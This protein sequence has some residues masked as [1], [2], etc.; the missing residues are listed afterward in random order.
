MKKLF[1]LFLSSFL[2][3]LSSGCS[4]DNDNTEK[5]TDIS[6]KWMLEKYEV[7]SFK[8]FVKD[9]SGYNLV[10]EIKSGKTFIVNNYAIQEKEELSFFNPGEYEITEESDSYKVNINGSIYWMYIRDNNLIVDL[11]PL[12]GPRYSFRLLKK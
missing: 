3:C 11:S 8:H 12:D 9:C 2:I 6:G 5:I 7:Y 1:I 4:D 10:V